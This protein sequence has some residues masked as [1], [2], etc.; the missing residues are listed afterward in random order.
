VTTRIVE[1]PVEDTYDLRRRVLRAGTPS[2]AVTFA[3]DDAP[4]TV[5]VAAVDD[6][7]RIVGIA[8]SLAAPCPHRPGRTARRLRGMAV[9]D[10]QR[11]SGIGLL[12]LAALVERARTAGAGVVWADARDSA[13]GF[14]RRAGFAVVGEGFVTADTALPHHV[15]VLDIADEGCSARS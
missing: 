12:L 10:S 3:A 9:E 8:T 7:G 13:L 15:V 11:G 14:Y 5:H 4:D 6:D 1:V 2:G